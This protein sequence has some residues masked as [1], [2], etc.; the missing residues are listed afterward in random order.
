M[1]RA[2]SLA[3]VLLCALGCGPSRARWEPSPTPPDRASFALVRAGASF[4]VA[5]DPSAPAVSLAPPGAERAPWLADTFLAV[6]VLAEGRSWARI[7]T[8]G[9]DTSAHCASEVPGLRPFRLRLY[10]TSRSLAQLTVREVDQPFDDGTSI[11]LARGVPLERLERPGYYRA[12]LGE[13]SAVVRLDATAVGGRYLPS[14][15]PPLVDP[16]GWLS[17]D[18]LRAGAPILGQTG[19]LQ[20]SGAAD[21]P[22]AA[23]EPRGSESLV[24]LRGRCGVLRARVPAHQV[25]PEG[26]RG[27][28]IDAPDD[29]AGPWIAPGAA[30]SWPDGRPAGTV[31]ARVALGREVEAGQHDL[32]CFERPLYPGPGRGVVLCVGRADVRGA[33]VEPRESAPGAAGGLAPPRE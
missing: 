5:P 15:P 26:L 20:S 33:A 9:E 21:V 11:R 19:R 24:E 25:V 3:C 7:E 12:R 2:A 4:H 18:A 30:L 32:R 31:T 29:A 1:T 27:E 14:A 13:L 28:V 6:H 10:V 17:A 23:L 22:L 8:P 16:V